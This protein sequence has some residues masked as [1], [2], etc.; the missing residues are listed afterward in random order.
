M[1]THRGGTHQVRVVVCRNVVVFVETAI[2]ELD[3]H[4][5]VDGIVPN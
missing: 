5:V 1:L 2:G 4:L 3:V